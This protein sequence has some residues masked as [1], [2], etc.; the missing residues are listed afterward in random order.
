[1]WEDVLRTVRIIYW[2]I[3]CFTSHWI[4]SSHTHTCHKPSL[5]TSFLKKSVLLNPKVQVVWKTLP[6][7]A[8]FPAVCSLKFGCSKF[9]KFWRKVAFE[10][11]KKRKGRVSY[12]PKGK[13][14]KQTQNKKHTKKCPAQTKPRLKVQRLNCW[15]RDMLCLV[16]WALGPLPHQTFLCLNHDK[17]NSLSRAWP[18]ENIRDALNRMEVRG[19]GLT[20]KAKSSSF[21]TPTMKTIL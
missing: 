2:Y 3:Y 18:T 11:N 19:P 5:S 4:L 13:N 1:M 10:S 21:V 17:K 12:R 16:Q 14:K 9:L 8:H 15:G 20:P 6:T 7:L